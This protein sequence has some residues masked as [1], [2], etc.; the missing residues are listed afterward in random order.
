[1]A[2]VQIGEKLE[3]TVGR[4]A[5]G[6]DGVARYEGLA[7]FVPLAAPGDRLIV[8]ITERKKN[9]ARARIEEVLAAS[10]IRR[11][12]LCKYFGDCGGCQ[13]QHVMYP[14]QLDAKVGFIRDALARIARIDWT[15]PIEIRSAAEFGYRNR[16]QVKLERSTSSA[17]PELRIGFN[18]AGSH[19]VCD[20]E[21]CPILLPELDR[22]LGILREALKQTASPGSR[23]VEFELA[24]GDNAV[25]VQPQVEHLPRA[26][27]ASE[28]LGAR[29]TFSPGVFFQVNPFLVEQLVREAIGDQA[30]ALAIDLYAGVGLFTIQ[31]ARRFERVIG[32][33]V[34][35]RAAAFARRN[36]AAN[37]L[38]NVEFRNAPVEA[39][40]AGLVKNTGGD[41][42]VDLLLLDPPRTGAAVAIAHIV[43]LRPARI[44]YVSCDPPTL[45]RDVRLLVDGGYS[46][47]RVTAFD[48][49]PQTYHVETVAWLSSGERRAS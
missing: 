30:G 15:Q 5:Y 27:I 23:I 32:V 37:N 41:V 31:L 22:A 24:A 7:I 29:Y 25:A 46:L 35:Q 11:Q 19:S 8:R 43:Q 36:I 3:V 42:A 47:E 48:M 12:A 34:D 38:G 40:L 16:A 13:L 14:S 18:R 21:S 28:V 17:G 2:G 6:G 10:S 45:A 49:F 4:L 44:V 20:V 39:S 26:E 9:F 33:E 1:M